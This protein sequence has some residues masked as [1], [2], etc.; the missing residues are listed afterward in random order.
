[1]SQLFANN[2][3]GALTAAIASGDTSLVLSSSGEGALFP[4]ATV[5]TGAYSSGDWF[6]AVIQDATKFEIVYVRTHT[7]GSDTFTNVVRG[8]EGTTAAAFGAGAVVGIRPTA[9]DAKLWGAPVPTILWGGSAPDNGAGNDGDI[10]FHVASDWLYLYK[11]GYSTPGEW[12]YSGVKW[13]SETAF[14]TKADKGMIPAGSTN[15]IALTDV[16]GAVAIT[17]NTTIPANASVAIPVGACVLLQC[18]STARTIT[19]PAANS[20]VLEGNSSAVTSFTLKANKGAV[21][22]KTA[23][24]AW[25][26]YG[27]VS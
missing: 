13:A 3:R 26:V 23:T 21:I 18:G 22:R 9:E 11:K 15:A 4:V 6:K 24:D 17:A 14:N 7:S 12:I 10:Y 27:D 8:Q 25:H 20:L 2:A 5:G 16:G 1:M 19:G